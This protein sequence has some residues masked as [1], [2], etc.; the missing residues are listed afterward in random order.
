LLEKIIGDCRGRGHEAGSSLGTVRG[1]RGRGSC[2]NVLEDFV[3][4]VL[5]SEQELPRKVIPF[6]ASRKGLS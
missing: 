2:R 5:E 1:C 6:V 4:L 3:G